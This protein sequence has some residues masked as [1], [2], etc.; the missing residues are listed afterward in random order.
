MDGNRE[1]FGHIKDR[2]EAIES[3]LI[4]QEHR[5]FKIFTNYFINRTKW[6]KSDRRRTASLKALV[7]SIFFSPGMIAA[8]GGVIA[9]LTLLVLF[10]QNN[11]I[12]DQN[13]LISNQNQFF[14]QQ[15]KQQQGQYE[16]N[17]RTELMDILYKEDASP[18]IKSEALMEYIALEKS[19]I[20]AEIEDSRFAVSSIENISL[21]EDNWET[22]RV[23]LTNAL[24]SGITLRSQDLS[25][26]NFTGAKMDNAHFVN[27]NLNN[28]IIQNA[29]L[30][31]SEFINASFLNTVWYGAKI[32]EAEF[33]NPLKLGF[34]EFCRTTGHPDYFEYKL[35]DSLRMKCQSLS[36][37]IV[38]R[39]DLYTKNK[40]IEQRK[41]IEP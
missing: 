6:E 23:N 31:K 10:W 30:R 25:F 3:Q 27:V 12:S 39:S 9:I 26:V 29:D 32:D 34:Y 15:I 8:T 16:L 5:P 22:R 28:S 36:F 4:E 1:E 35:L 18:R 20:Q 33:E 14:Q 19:L 13:N 11:I 41:Q 17:R 7:Y 38:P 37:R 40:Y 24:L 2:I 21:N